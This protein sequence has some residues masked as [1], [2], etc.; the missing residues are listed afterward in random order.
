MENMEHLAYMSRCLQLAEAG[1]G[2]VAPNP[3]VGCVIVC[4]GEI[5]GDGYHIKYGGAHAE[6]N[7]I[8]SV[9]DKSLLLD[10]TL[11]V[12]MEPCSHFGKTPPCA[13]RIIAEGIPRVVYGCRDT[14]S[15][16]NGEGIRKLQ[17]AGLEVIGGVLE[18]ESKFINRRFFCYHENKRPYIILKWAQTEDSFISRSDYTS[19]WISSESSRLLVHK[20]RSEEQAILIGYH[21]LL[22][23]RPRLDSRDMKS[24]HPVRIVLLPRSESLNHFELLQEDIPTYYMGG[25]ERR[26]FSEQHIQLPIN[27]IQGVLNFLHSLKIQS[28]IVEGG[29]KVL[30]SFIDA[31]LWDEARIFTSKVKFETGINAP[32]VDGSTLSLE[33]IENDELKIILRA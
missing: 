28:L 21:T 6:V 30:N 17:E 26:E 7:A 14:S 12:N 9:I 13:D 16:V 8:E 15:L 31:Q 4:K 18:Q 24:R 10:S 25:N 23:D 1:A 2:N 19:K 5:I 3:K 32:V 11:Y 22:R 27:D 29:A 20:W 33:N